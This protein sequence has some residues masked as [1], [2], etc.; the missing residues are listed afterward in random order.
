MCVG[1]HRC[2]LQQCGLYRDSS[3]SVQ[4]PQVPEQS[5][6]IYRQYVSR[7][8]HGA[9][10]PT[11]HDLQIYQQYVSSNDVD[12]DASKSSLVT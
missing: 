12:V 5:L 8:I 9:G 7:G 6:E 4:P 10:P 2:R 11:D 1:L 3:Y